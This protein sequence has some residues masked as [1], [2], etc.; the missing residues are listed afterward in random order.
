MTPHHHLD[1]S[2]IVAYAAGTLDEAF[3]VVVASHVAMCP[4]C[5]RS[6][7]EAEAYG[8]EFMDGMASR[9]VSAECRARTMA[10][11]DRA[12]PYR[13]PAPAPH[14]ELPGPLSQLL[15]VHSFDALNWKKKAPGVAMV[16]V[17]L[18][19]HSHGQLKLLKIGPGRA[20][21]EHGHGGEEITLVLKGSY[22]DHMGRFAR[23]DV[24]DLDEDV[25]HKP[26]AGTEGDCVC[27]VAIERPT[28]FKSLTARLLQPLVGI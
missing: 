24:A 28:R 15:K 11:L 20:M 21:P 25:E 6:V 23:G 19:S 5:R 7:R 9:S 12:S 3:S 16:D 10:A 17:R 22:H 14:S 8:G 27:L 26:V 2:T 4:E 1:H 13:L 18:S